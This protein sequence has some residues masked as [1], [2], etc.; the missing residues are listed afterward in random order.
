MLPEPS[1][2]PFGNP[3]YARPWGSPRVVDDTPLMVAQ[4]EREIHR[5]ID[6]FFHR[7][8]KHHLPYPAPDHSDGIF[9]SD[10][11]RHSYAL[12]MYLRQ[13]RPSQ[14]PID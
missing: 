12:Q 4:P 3:G 13:R 14:P 7:C 5:M 10:L 2:T 6:S 11:Y 9:G 8:D 1:T